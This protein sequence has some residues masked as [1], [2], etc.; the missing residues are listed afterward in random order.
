MKVR[1]VEKPPAQ[2]QE[3]SLL[4]TYVLFL[5]SLFRPHGGVHCNT[6]DEGVPYGS[7]C[8]SAMVLFICADLL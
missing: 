2:R 3:A 5:H 4:V 1:S 6:H 7:L 8:V